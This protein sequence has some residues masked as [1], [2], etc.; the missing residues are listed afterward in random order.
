MS[1][2]SL[3]ETILRTIQMLPHASLV[4]AAV[5]LG[6]IGL[7][8]LL[9]AR[10]PHSPAPLVGVTLGIAAS[11]LFG[12]KAIGVDTVGAIPPGLPQLTPPDTTL[13]PQLWAGALGIALIS[14]TESVAAGRA[15]VQPARSGPTP[16]R[17]CWRLASVTCS[18]ASL[19]PCRQAEART[20][21]R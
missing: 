4:T 20:R 5:G 3:L 2:R 14:F 18:A 10:I 1:P 13:A 9:E 11:A 12:L 15:F 17:S 7:M 6:T 16:I 19:A 21:R 8:A